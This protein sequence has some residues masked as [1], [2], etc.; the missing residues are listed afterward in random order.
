MT[1][2]LLGRHEA[3]YPSP[4]VFNPDRFLENPRLDRYQI[5]FSRGSRRCLGVGELL[6]PPPNHILIQNQINL[7]YSELYTML[8]GIFR[9]YDLFDGTGTQTGPTL[10]L[11]ETTRQDVDMVADFATPYV[12]EG[13]L[14]V[15]L[16]VR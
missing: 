13:S 4:S 3:I 16:I 10:E 7:A 11:Y 14:G 8:A 1:A 6:P 15:R 2:N 9:K 12:K 5:A